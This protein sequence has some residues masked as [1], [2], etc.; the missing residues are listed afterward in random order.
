MHTFRKPNIIS[1][2]FIG[3]I[4]LAVS[5]ASGQSGPSTIFEWPPYLTLQ[6]DASITVNWRTKTLSRGAL[7]VTQTD[8]KREFVRILEKKPSLHH[9]ITINNLV[10]GNTYAYQVKP[11]DSNVFKTE[12]I[13]FQMSFGSDELIFFVISD[14]HQVLP[15]PGLNEYVRERTHRVVQGMLQDPLTPDFLVNCG[16]HVEEDVLP[17]WTAYFQVMH[18]MTRKIPLF[19]VVGNHEWMAGADNYFEAFSFPHGGGRKGWEWYTF[20]LKNVL[21]IFL[22]MNFDDL[23]QINRQNA[24]LKSVLHQNKDKTWKLVFT[25]QPLYSSSERYSAEMPYQT[26]FEPIFLKHGVDVVFSGHHHAY[27]RIQ[28]KGITHIVSAGGGGRLSELKPEKVKGTVTT[29]EK[30]LHYLRIRIANNRFISDVRI[31]GEENAREIM[32]PR[33]ETFDR[34]EII[35]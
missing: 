5:T 31:V 22:N 7:I 26:L 19:P 16:D 3:L 15:V 34:F 29:R 8:L 33:N 4:L 21:L 1:F 28:R 11:A 10:P 18:P 6:T 13:Q 17:N 14:T 27:Q 12:P 20:Q 24:W 30:V 35:K 2:F 32:E 9:H 25:H 23:D